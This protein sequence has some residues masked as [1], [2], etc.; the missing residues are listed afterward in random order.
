MYEDFASRG[1]QRG[2][3]VIEL[4]TENGL[5]RR[6]CGIRPR[7]AEEIECEFRLGEQP[8]PQT[9][10]KIV[11]NRTQTGDEVILECSNGPFGGIASMSMRWYQLVLYPML[12]LEQ[13]FDRSGGL[14]VHPM[15]C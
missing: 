4:F 15:H 12:F 8:V 11:I 6:L 1:S 13:T 5:I 7:V 3:I 14:I 10:R 9:N 2:R